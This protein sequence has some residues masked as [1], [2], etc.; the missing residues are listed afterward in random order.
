MLDL[1]RKVEGQ[2]FEDGTKLKMISISGGNQ[3]FLLPWQAKMN[4]LNL[5]LGDQEYITIKSRCRFEIFY[6]FPHFWSRSNGRSSS[7]LWDCCRI[8]NGVGIWKSSHSVN[9]MAP[10]VDIRW[11]LV[12]M[13]ESGFSFRGN[14]SNQHQ[15]GQIETS[16]ILKEETVSFLYN[17]TLLE[18]VQY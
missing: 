6:Y 3:L 13:Y 8:I 18:V 11:L 7:F 9:R 16:K 14:Q 17:C 1:K 5:N 10:R 4:Y 12:G 15:N 2:R